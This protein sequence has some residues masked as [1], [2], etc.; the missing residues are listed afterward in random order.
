MKK[1]SVQKVS[2]AAQNVWVEH[3]SPDW[4]LPYLQLSRWDRPIGWWLLLIPCWWGLL[5]AINATNEPRIFDL[6]ILIGCFLGAVLMRGAGC[7]WNDLT[8]HHLDAL[9]ARTQSRPLPSGRVSRPNA[10][11][12]LGVQSLLAALILFT[13]NFFTIL[14]GLISLIPVIIYPF[15]KRFTW[16]PQ[17]FLGIAFNWGALVGWSAHTGSLDLP[18]LLLYG[19]GIM[20]TIFYDT[21]YA[22]QDR[23]DDIISGIKSTALLFGSHTKLWLGV[24]G[25]LTVLLLGGAILASWNWQ[26]FNPISII[27][28]LTSLFL[29][30][31]HLIWQLKK[32]N[33]NSPEICLSVFRSNRDCGL[34]IAFGLALAIVF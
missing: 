20:W 29:F 23:T 13:F 21:I 30:A 28:T 5:L 26:F 27:I 3:L 2:D 8:D 12:W 16:W 32:L 17:I 4:F 31:G 19:A 22:H 18:S 33:I 14:I 6:W 24:F 25:I 9:V 7:T 15:A 11:L 1:I 10:Y 34:L